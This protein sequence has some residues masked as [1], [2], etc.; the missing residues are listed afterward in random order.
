MIQGYLQ[1]FHNGK[2]VAPI[3]GIV[4]K[5]GVGMSERIVFSKSGSLYINIPRDVISKSGIKAGQR[6]SVSFL[7]GVGIVVGLP[8]DAARIA[9]MF[10]NYHDPRLDKKGGK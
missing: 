3:P 1:W 7:W 4:G 6:V 9:R 8:G 5:G 10:D 2:G